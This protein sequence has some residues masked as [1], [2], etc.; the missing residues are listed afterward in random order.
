MDETD[1]EY[2]TN[3]MIGEGSANFLCKE[4]DKYFRLCGPDIV[5]V[6]ATE[7]CHYSI[8][9]ARDKYVNIVWAVL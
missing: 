1:L 4:P 8:K 7:L 2:I 6:A 3:E 9:G 5:S